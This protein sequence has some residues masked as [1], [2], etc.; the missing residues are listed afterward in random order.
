MKFIKKIF[1][2]TKAFYQHTNKGMPKADQ[3]TINTR[4]YICQGCESFDAEKSE[5]KECG[6]GLSRKKEFFNKLAWED[7]K[8]PI[9]KW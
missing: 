8:C 2:F 9:G 5:C 4:Y 3:K 6:C 1:N 7:Q